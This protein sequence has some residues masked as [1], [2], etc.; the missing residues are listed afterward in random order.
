MGWSLRSIDEIPGELSV[1]NYD[2]QQRIQINRLEADTSRETLGVHI[3]PAGTWLEQK[4]ALEKVLTS[5]RSLLKTA[6]LSKEDIKCAIKTM[7]WKNRIST[8]CIRY[9]K[10]RM[11][12]YSPPN[13]SKCSERIADK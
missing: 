6:H 2:T 1:M 12:H 3:S 4:E 13:N 8:S 7:L 9:F 11:G 5:F 10:N